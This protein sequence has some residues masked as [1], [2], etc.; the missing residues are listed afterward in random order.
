MTII[1][2]RIAFKNNPHFN[3]LLNKRLLIYRAVEDVRYDVIRILGGMYLELNKSLITIKVN[4]K[5][6]NYSIVILGLLIKF[7]NPFPLK[8]VNFIFPKQYI[9]NITLNNKIIEYQAI[10]QIKY[11]Y[12]FTLCISSI[13]NH[14]TAKTIVDQTLQIYRKEGVSHAIIY[15]GDISKEV[16]NILLK[17]TKIGFLE[18]YYWP[19]IEILSYIRN[20][21]QILKMNDCLY[22]SYYNSKYVINSDMDEI[23]MPKRFYTLADLI[24]HYLQVIPKCGIFHFFSKTF[25]TKNYTDNTNKDGR[26]AYFNLPRVEDVNIFEKTLSCKETMSRTKYIISTLKVE[27]IQ[28]HNAVTS[29]KHC[30]VSIKDGYC[31][32]TRVI[33]QNNVLLCKNLTHDTTINKY[34]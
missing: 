22:R 4:G 26:D 9:H 33:P 23:I 18:I 2:D 31:R 7:N 24:N 30:R 20:Y 34:K 11:K 27:A 1:N 14:F 10:D 25:P 12:N 5:E 8:Y 15:Y 17:Y 16:Y 6:V 21:G 29:D 32:H 3:I 28:F 19:S 13:K